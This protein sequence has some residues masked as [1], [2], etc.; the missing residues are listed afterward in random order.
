M[1]EIVYKSTTEDRS[2]ISRMRYGMEPADNACTV[3]KKDDKVSIL[4][5]QFVVG[6]PTPGSAKRYYYWRT[7]SS[8]GLRKNANGSVVPYHCTRE[9]KGRG[10]GGWTFQRPT[11][12]FGALAQSGDMGEAFANAVEE[13]FGVTSA[14]D[15]YPMMERYGFDKYSAVPSSLLPAFRQTD[16]EGMANMVFGKTRS[17]SRMIK[18]MSQTDPFFVAFA[19]QFRG[20]VDDESLVK[21]MEK[22]HF[23]ENMENV[24]KPFSPNIRKLLL[25]DN[26]VGQKYASRMKNMINKELDMGDLWNISNVASLSVRLT[27]RRS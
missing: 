23:D 16:F 2:R 17:S 24:F 25:L 3:I 5:S 14:R 1:F 4:G 8:L 22:N 19:Q 18:A 10:N 13:T 26:A 20:L 7:I 15:L 27:S 9:W 11:T 12:V 6:V 21:F